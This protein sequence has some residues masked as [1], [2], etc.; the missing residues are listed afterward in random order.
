MG[1][2]GPLKVPFAAGTYFRC[3]PSSWLLHRFRACAKA[4]KPVLG[5]FHPYDIDTAQEYVMNCGVRRNQLM[6]RLLFF[7]RHRTLSRLNLTLQEGFRILPYCEF[8]KNAS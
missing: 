5:Y 8:L 7:N 1:R 3:L 4:G 2:F 6:N